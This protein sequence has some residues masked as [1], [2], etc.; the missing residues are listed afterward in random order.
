MHFVSTHCGTQY[1]RFRIRLKNNGEDGEEEPLEQQSVHLAVLAKSSCAERIDQK[2]CVTYNYSSNLQFMLP[3]LLF[4]PIIVH[5]CLALRRSHRKHKRLIS[6]GFNRSC[7]KKARCKQKLEM[8]PTAQE[9]SCSCTCFDPD[10]RGR[11]NVHIGHQ[12]ILISCAERPWDLSRAHTR[13]HNHPRLKG[14]SF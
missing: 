11:G 10:E 4:V 3:N 8:L 7:R 12:R 13:F 6:W 14:H 5:T 2:I 1:R 9:F